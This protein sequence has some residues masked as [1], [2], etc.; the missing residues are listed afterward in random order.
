MAD[1]FGCVLE[2]LDGRGELSS[3]IHP[4][5]IGTG[6]T[7]GTIS[8]SYTSLRDWSLLI[9]PQGLHPDLAHR[10]HFGLGDKEGDP[11]S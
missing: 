6:E 1:V 8:V 9:S 3:R 4:A 11:D 10:Q 5:S 2:T 7:G